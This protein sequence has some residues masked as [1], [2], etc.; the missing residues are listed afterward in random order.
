MIRETL[1]LTIRDLKKYYRAKVQVLVTFVQPLVWLGLFGQAFRLEDLAGGQ[2]PGGSDFFAGAPNYFSF[3]SVG[4]LCIVI[5]FT[6]MFSGLNFVWDRRF[7]FLTKLR[8]SPIPRG[9]IPLSRILAFS[10]RALIQAMIVFVVAILFVF[11]PGVSGLELNGFGPLEF[12]GMVLMLGLLALGFS[13]LFTTIGLAIENQ[14]TFMGVVNLLNL[15]IMFSSSALFPT[16]LMPDWLKGVAQVNPIT[17][18]SDG[19]RQMIFENPDPLY[20][21]QMDILGLVIF[22]GGLICIGW[23]MAIKILNR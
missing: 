23:V 9:S 19:I 7:G 21:L 13:T 3:M 2:V 12:L 20:S 14:E 8:A 6:C 4:M 22:A 5:L 15:P 10:T 11:I 17:F 16:K 1:A 18:A